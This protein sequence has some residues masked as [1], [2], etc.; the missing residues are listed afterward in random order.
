MMNANTVLL[1]R[2]SKWA[3]EAQQR[4]PLLR[5]FARLPETGLIRSHNEA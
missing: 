3:K 4:A 5:F 1:K 2:P